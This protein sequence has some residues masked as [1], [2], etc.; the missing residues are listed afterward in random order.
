MNI[1]RIEDTQT[2][3][4]IPEFRSRDCIPLIFLL[5]ALAFT[6]SVFVVAFFG[7]PWSIARKEWAG[8]CVSILF[9][10]GAAWLIKK[11][12][13]AALNSVPRRIVF[14]KLADS[15]EIRRLWFRRVIPRQ[16]VRE[17]TLRFEISRGGMK[18]SPGIWVYLCLADNA[19]NCSSILI[20]T[21]SSLVL[22]QRN[23]FRRLY[24]EFCSF[25]NSKPLPIEIVR[26]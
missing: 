7:I 15:F 17:I 12:L 1:T 21:V 9:V 22:E 20:G 23:I 11:G 3:T 25:S 10:T 18:T 4:L 19:G 24:R 14:S 16:A 5:F 2:L 26:I 13:R 8:L 6:G